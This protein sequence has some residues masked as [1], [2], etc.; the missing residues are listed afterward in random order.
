MVYAVAMTTI[1]HFEA[2]LGRPALWAAQRAKAGTGEFDTYVQRLRIYPH[3]LREANAYYS[4]TKKAL[5]FGYFPAEASTVT[6]DDS[7]DGHFPGGWVFTCLSHDVIAHE[8]THALLDGMHR[9]YIEPTH[10][11]NLAFHE[12]FADLVALFQ[13]FTFPEVLRHQIARTRGNLTSQNLLGQLAQQFGTAVGKH[14]ALRDAIGTIADG[15]W[16]PSKP[17]PTAITTTFEPHGGGAI[18]VAAVFDAF[19]AVYSNRV[20]GPA[21]DRDER[22]WCAPRRRPAPGSCEPAR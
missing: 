6:T 19:L 20:R 15:E 3:A 12:A 2:A 17:D 11:D 10:P 1:H 9:R 4:P 7:R 14:G 16:V 21:A 5:L 18:L 8:T 22:H 13:H